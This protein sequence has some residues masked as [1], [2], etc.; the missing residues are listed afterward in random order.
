MEKTTSRKLARTRLMERQQAAAAAREA[1]ERA[2]IGDLT[3]FMVSAA[4]VD[5][6]D[7]W[8]A[9]RIEKVKTE[10]DRKRERHRVAAGNALQRMR[11][12]GETV[13]SIAAQAGLSVSRVREYLHW[14]TEKAN[15]GAGEDAN[16][17]E[18]QVVP[19]PNHSRGSDDGHQPG[20]GESVAQ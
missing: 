4:E 18:A 10:A 15:D 20:E 7:L 11:M 13:T 2:N 17:A 1:R 14:A 8:L 3:E 6:V 9:A 12:R 16:A 5:E 19:M